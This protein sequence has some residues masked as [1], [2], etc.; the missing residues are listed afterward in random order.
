MNIAAQT[1]WNEYWGNRDSPSS[2]SAWM[3]GDTSDR[4]AEQVI[5]GVKTA[6]CSG[7]VFYELENKPLPMIDEYGIIL[8]S[9]E[10]PVAIIK[11]VKVSLIPFNEV[12]KE[13]AIAEGDGTY[14]NW[15]DIHVN[16][17]SSELHKYGLGFSEDM[18]LV[19]EKFM[20]IDIKK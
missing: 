10:Q 9:E 17:F 16:Y 3:F 11:T 13:F 7:H 8:N 5:T 1:Y 2:V 15:K 4:L 19:C 6:T 14:Q 20:L 12:T 18:L